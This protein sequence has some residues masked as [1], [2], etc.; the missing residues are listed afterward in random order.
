[1][2]LLL[3]SIAEAKTGKLL[4]MSGAHELSTMSMTQK[5]GAMRQVQTAVKM[6][7]AAAIGGIGVSLMVPPPAIL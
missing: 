4:A 5:M 7:S 3:F 2:I 1:M 6:A